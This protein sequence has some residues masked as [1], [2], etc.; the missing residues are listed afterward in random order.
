MVIETLI[1]SYR[2]VNPK[3]LAEEDR[4]TIAD[5]RTRVDDCLRNLTPI[6]DFFPID[7]TKT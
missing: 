4:S 1:G 3:I 7:L 2:G 6:T 5:V